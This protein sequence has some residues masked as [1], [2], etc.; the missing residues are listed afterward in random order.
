MALRMVGPRVC[1]SNAILLQTI[2][3]PS[4]PKILSVFVFQRIRLWFFR[5]C[6]LASTSN[7]FASQRRIT[8]TDSES[9]STSTIMVWV[10]VDKIVVLRGASTVILWSPLLRP[11]NVPGK[12]F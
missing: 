4:G 9:Y 5:A 12:P 3:V 8:R 11:L 10:A 6:G 1:L 2:Y 7:S